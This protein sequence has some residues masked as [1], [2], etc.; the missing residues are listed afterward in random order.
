MILALMLMAGGE[1]FF[2]VAKIALAAHV[3]VIVIEGVV[4]GFTIGFLARVKPSLLQSDIFQK[5]AASVD[6]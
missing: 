2:G 6:D 4:S 3:P 1:D 5:T